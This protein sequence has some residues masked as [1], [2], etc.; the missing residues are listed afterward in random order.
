[1]QLQLL[2]AVALSCVL[3]GSAIAQTT[4]PGAPAPRL[5]GPEKQASLAAAHPDTTA[6]KG[7]PDAVAMDQAVIT[8]KGGCT[9]VGGLTPAKDCVSEVTKAQF[10]KLTT[11]LQ[12]GMNWDMKRGF[13]TNYGKLLVY[14]DA[15]RALNLESNPDVVQVIQFVTNQVLA[16]AVK[17][18]YADEYAHPSDQQIEEYYKQN[19]AKYIEANLERMI[20]PHVPGTPQKPAPSDA[21]QAAA[22]EKIRQ[23]WIAG[24]DPSKLQQSAYELAGVTGTG[25]PDVSLG[26]RRPGSLPVN[27]EAV[28]RLK[29]GEISQVFSDP[30]AYY[31]YKAV[32]VREIPVSEVRDSISKT[33]QQRQM[34]DKL[35]EIGKSATPV[36]NEV[37]FGPAP[38]PGGPMPG[39]RP[40]PA[41]APQ[42]SNPPK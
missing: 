36:L 22:A 39:G 40:G 10:E 12:P 15:A 37:Y 30:A 42:A 25:S 28:F 9:P 35:D 5:H 23:Q 14:A 24:G 2:A 41:G 4:S 13:A 11:A 8:L 29:A 17:R 20:V 3:A 6:P 32:S 38:V 27:Q 21:D 26:A 34:Q 7:N 16:E 19:S 18:H 31:I 33:L 1:M